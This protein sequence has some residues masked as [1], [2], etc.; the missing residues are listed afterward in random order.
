MSN[1]YTNIKLKKDSDD[2]KYIVKVFDYRNLPFE[3]I[4]KEQHNQTQLKLLNIINNSASDK[5]IQDTAKKFFNEELKNFEKISKYSKII[6]PV[7]YSF[8]SAAYVIFALHAKEN[9]LDVGLILGIIGTTFM[10][11]ILTYAH[12]VGL[13]EKKHCQKG[14]AL[15]KE[16]EVE[17]QNNSHPKEFIYTK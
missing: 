3:T 5:Y 4:E 9:G 1:R 2:P 16:I 10:L 13:Y 7:A 6:S 12:I 11:V 8:Y 15:L 14:L 17:N